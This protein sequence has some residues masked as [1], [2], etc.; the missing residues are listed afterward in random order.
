MKRCGVTRLSGVIRASVRTTVLPTGIA[1]PSD[2]FLWLDSL[3]WWSPLEVGRAF[4]IRDVDDP[5]CRALSQFT[6]RQAVS[7]LQRGI[8]RV[9]AGL[10]FDAVASALPVGVCSG[11]PLRYGAA[12]AGIDTFAGLVRERCDELGIEWE[13]VFASESDRLA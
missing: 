12:F 4:G 1:S 11:Q 2:H 13:Y 5:L 6:P 3:Q 9:T 10:A 7:A 8:V